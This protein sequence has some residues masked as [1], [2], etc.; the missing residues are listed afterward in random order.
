MR[1]HDLVV[2]F[3]ICQVL[4][5][6]L[7]WDVSVLSQLCKEIISESV[8][9]ATG[10]HVRTCVGVIVSDERASLLKSRWLFWFPI[11]S[12]FVVIKLRFTV[13]KQMP[14]PKM[15]PLIINKTLRV[16]LL[17]WGCTL[18]SAE[19]GVCA[20]TCV[21]RRVYWPVLTFAQSQMMAKQDFITKLH[22]LD[23]DQT[24]VDYCLFHFDF[25]KGITFLGVD[26]SV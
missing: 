4:P 21:H 16:C 17:C 5:L 18:Y 24:P 7:K 2:Q 15:T 26:Q 11:G 23:S 10:T 22:W 25:N 8:R 20:Q 14:N 12:L 19:K 6:T 9:G 1:L 3:G 13:I